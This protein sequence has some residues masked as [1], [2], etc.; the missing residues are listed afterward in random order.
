MTSTH[1]TLVTFYFHGSPGWHGP[2]RLSKRFH[3]FDQRKSRLGAAD[4]LIGIFL[5][6]CP[7]AGEGSSFA[8]KPPAPFVFKLP[9][10]D[11][12]HKARQKRQQCP[13]SWMKHPDQQV[14]LTPRETSSSVP[15]VEKQGQGRAVLSWQTQHCQLKSDEIAAWP[16]YYCVA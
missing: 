11:D 12:R 13:C 10:R 15:V 4:W 8:C 9:D 1:F 7:S 3:T 16:R 14:R 2:D 5:M 6:L